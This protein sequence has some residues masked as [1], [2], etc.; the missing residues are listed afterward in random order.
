M[1]TPQG[2]VASPLL[3]NIYMRRFL[4]AW[5]KRKLPRELKAYVVNYADDFV[6]LCRGTAGRREEEAEKI[7]TGMK[8]RMNQE[9]TRVVDASR[10]PF[11]FLGYTFGIVLRGWSP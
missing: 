10:E 5:E 4:L 8:L 9:K 1:G 11:D 6:I 2:G 3:A 7:I